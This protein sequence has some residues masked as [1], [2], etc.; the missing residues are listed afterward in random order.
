MAQ[1]AAILDIDG[2]LVDSNYE[3]VRAWYGAFREHGVTV[4]QAW[5]HRSTGMGGD[6]LVPHLLGWAED[7]PRVKQVG[8]RHDAIFSEQYMA[9]IQPLPG[10]RA[11]LDRLLREGIAVALGTSAKGEEL[12][13]YV[14]L[15]G[16]QGQ[17]AATVSKADVGQTKPAPEVFGEVLRTLGI[18]VDDA[19]AVGDSVWDGEAARKLGLCFVG[20]R[21]GG[22]GEAEL[23]GASAVQ[24]YDDLPA[25]LAGWDDGPFGTARR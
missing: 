18:G 21:T 7:D 16:L 24:V 19:V 5:I 3:H 11:F 2:T 4:P 13:H 9:G 1:R 10:A 14:G 22:F 6:K 17:L 15:L 25:L 12:E 20:L 8:E 23:R